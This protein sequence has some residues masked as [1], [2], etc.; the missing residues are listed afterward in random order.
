[1]ENES[2][3]EGRNDAN[4]KVGRTVYRRL[5]T[6]AADESA[7]VESASSNESPIETPI[8]A[9]DKR[10]TTAPKTSRVSTMAFQSLAP[11]LIPLLCGFLLLLGIVYF[12]GRKS[13]GELNRVSGK[14]LDMQRQRSRQ[15]NILLNVK[16]TL[17][18][19]NNEARLRGERS[20]RGGIRIPFTTRLD[21]ARG[22]M[23]T[24]LEEFSRSAYSNTNDGR[25]FAN[26]LKNFIE[27]ASDERRYSSEGFDAFARLDRELEQILQAETAKQEAIL[28]RINELQEAAEQRIDSLT[29]L[30][31]MVGAIAAAAT[32]WEVQRRFRS[33]GRSLDETRRERQFSH[34][35]LEGMVSAV[36]T[37]DNEN[38]FTTLNEA[39]RHTFQE[40]KVGMS[41]HDAI[42]DADAFRALAMTIA[43]PVRRPAYRGRFMLGEAASNNGAA[44]ARTF[45][46]YVA[47]LKIEGE[48]GAILTFV[49]VTEAANAESELRRRASLAAMGQATAQIAHEIKNPLGS[50]R[51]GVSLL[52][53]MATEPD[54]ILTIDLVDRGIAHLNKLTEDVTQFS[55]QRELELQ[56][57]DVH[58]ILEGSLE[59]VRDRVGEKRVSIEKNFTNQPL[60]ALVDADALRQV[61]VNIIANA[62]DASDEGGRIKIS[63]SEISTTRDTKRIRISIADYGSGI[64]ERARARL[65]EPFFTTKKR[66]TGLGLA[67]TKNIIEQHGGTISIESKVGK[68]TVFT[69]ELPLT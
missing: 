15:L 35:V 3:N 37:L 20:A 8:A 26:N 31:L 24:L 56:D 61:F 36:A 60:R 43:E 53:D 68:G 5:Q 48:R 45:D 44:G 47:P 10:L 28:Q 32:V 7:D 63:T 13:V 16:T 29:L 62:I 17:G 50:I 67:I 39:F 6:D 33:L 4:E 34:Q 12:L 46:A 11:T 58:K 21:N 55:S 52:R 25:A 9:P 41:I 2:N 54:T 30:A 66:G 27:I 51:L 23:E 57:A 1:M 14:A 49:D 69:I 40:A 42:D 64:D 22:E 18:N 19:L 65:F 59:L 38:R